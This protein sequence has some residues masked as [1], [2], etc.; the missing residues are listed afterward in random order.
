MP[1]GVLHSA[2][3]C[4]SVAAGP[5]QQGSQSAAEVPV[6]PYE[7]RFA[8]TSCGG[9]GRMTRSAWIV[10][11]AGAEAAPAQ[12]RKQSRFKAI[13]G[14]PTRA[15]ATASRAAEDAHGHSSVEV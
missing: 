2:M 14:W 7:V 6:L 8:P 1:P 11:W 12:G 15:T 9:T 4:G 13:A 3:G 10:N 5:R